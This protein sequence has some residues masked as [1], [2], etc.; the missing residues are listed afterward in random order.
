MIKNSKISIKQLAGIDFEII[1]AASMKAFSDYPV[2]VVLSIQELQYMLERR[3]CDLSLSFGAFDNN[4]LIGFVLN[5]T[6][7]WQGN[8]T[9]YDTGTGLIKEYRRRGIATRLF[10]QSLPILRQNKIDQYLLEVIQENTSAFDLYQKEGLKVT[11]EF[12]CF[13]TPMSAIKLRDDVLN[14]DFSIIRVENPDWQ[15]FS[16]FWDFDP[17][18]QNSIDSIRRKIEHFTILAALNDGTPVG[19]GI[20]E[21]QTGDMPQIAIKKSY[22][23]RGIA[24]ELFRN[25]LS[26]SDSDELR[27]INTNSDSE[28]FKK[29]AESIHL[30]QSMDQYE[31]ILQL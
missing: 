12:N 10:K 3:G 17:S 30:H 6:G 20:I 1:Y 28:S 9:V 26:Y 14:D 19:Y 16:S 2:P 22:R 13:V 18:W 7:D 5:G 29:F 11:R 23:R 25:L 21:N 24:T 4:D 15:L 8:R 27:I 31:M